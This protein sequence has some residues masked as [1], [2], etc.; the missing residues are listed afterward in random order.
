MSSEEKTLFWKILGQLCLK[1]QTI[2]CDFQNF[3]WGQTNSNWKNIFKRYLTINVIYLLR[4]QLWKPNWSDGTTKQLKP[5][6]HTQTLFKAQI[7]WMERWAY[8]NFWIEKYLLIFLFLCMCVCACL[9][10]RT[11]G[12][13]VATVFP[14]IEASKCCWVSKWGK[15]TQN[16]FMN[17][18]R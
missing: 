5:S 14:E 10:S 6:K 3:Q 7:F 9:E 4:L 2:K 1:T 8:L 18:L 15:K 12:P 17:T 13:T 16:P 11:W